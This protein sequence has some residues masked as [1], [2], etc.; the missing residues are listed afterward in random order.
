[1]C[2]LDVGRRVLMHDRRF[3]TRASQWESTEVCTS[4]NLVQTGVALHIVQIQR[5]NVICN[6]Q[7]CGRK[8]HRLVGFT[9]AQCCSHAI[10]CEKL[11]NGPSSLAMPTPNGKCKSVG[12]T[13]MA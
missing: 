4:S 7:Y 9:C 1:M 11:A 5:S 2:D 3:D 6:R 12:K 8:A 10:L 13:S